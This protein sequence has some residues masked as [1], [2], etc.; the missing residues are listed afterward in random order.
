MSASSSGAAASSSSP[1][2]VKVIDSMD[3]RDS[4]ESSRQSEPISDERPS[5][6]VPTGNVS[7]GGRVSSS[8][9]SSARR[10]GELDTGSFRSKRRGGGGF[11][12]ADSFG[13]NR[14]ADLQ[15][16]GHRSPRDG[17]G[18]SKV[19]DEPLNVL[20]KRPANGR[21]GMNGSIRSSPLSKFT[22]AS[23]GDQDSRSSTEFDPAS[24]GPTNGENGTHQR[25]DTDENVPKPSGEAPLSQ[26]PGPAAGAIDPTQI[27][28]MALS[29]SESR[30]RNF[31]A[32]Q[33]PSQAISGRRVPSTG[34]TMTSPPLQGGYQNYGPGGSLRQYLNQQRRISRTISPG[35]T[36]RKTSGVRPASTSYFPSPPADPMGSPDPAVAPTYNWSTATLARVEKAKQYMELSSSHLGLLDFLPPLK[37]DSTAPGN[38]VYSASSV[39]GTA[40]FDLHRMQSK[41]NEKFPLGRQYNPLQLIRDR[42][43]RAR[44]RNCLNPDVDEFENVAQVREW[45]AAVEEGSSD[46]TYRGEDRAILPAYPLGSDPAAREA[47]DSSENGHRRNASIVSIRKRPRTDWLFS[48]AELLAEAYWLEQG[49]NKHLIENRHGNKIFPA[50]LKIEAHHPRASYEEKRSEYSMQISGGSLNGD[51]AD[52][53]S[54]RH[55]ERGRR[56]HLGHVDSGYK[57]RHVL[58]KARGRSP[59]P[60]S[61]LSTSDHEGR[62]SAKRPT[63]PLVT[64]FDDANVGPLERHME[65]ITGAEIQEPHHIGQTHISPG[66]PNKWGTDPRFNYLSQSP[67]GMA[68][69]DRIAHPETTA[70]DWEQRHSQSPERHLIH[71]RNIVDMDEPRSSMEE[72]SSTKPNSPIAEHFFPGLGSDLTPP[73]P[74]TSK[75]NRTHKS[76]K[77]IIPFIKSESSRDSRKLA[78]H[79]PFSDDSVFE[80]RPRKPSTEEAPP[81]S[82]FESMTGSEQGKKPFLHKT[83]ESI[84]SVG[85]RPSSRGKDAKD[86]KEP[87][88]AMR[89]FFKGGR[90]GE[91]VRTE[92]AKL[93]DAIRK[94]DSPQSLLEE[95]SDA[96]DVVAIESDSDEDL[97][98]VSAKPHE[99]VKRATT[100]S[101]SSQQLSP[102]RSDN[103]KP[104]FHIDNLPT[105]KSSTAK[106]SSE[107]SRPSTPT[108]DHISSQQRLL[109]QINR[110]PR[111]DRLAPP[112]LD[113]SRVTSR[114]ST[115]SPIT[116]TNQIYTTDSRDSRR[117][118]YGFPHLFHARSRSRLGKRLTA[119]LDVPGQVGRG[120]MPSTG[121]AKLKPERSASS[122]RRPQ[123]TMD[124]R[125]WSISDV[126]GAHPSV[127]AAHLPAAD[128]DATVSAADVTRVRA[129]LLCSGIKASELAWRAGH[130]RRAGP[131]P[132]LVRAAEASGRP[133]QEVVV[134]VREEF[135]MGGRLYSEVIE[136]DVD[137]LHASAQA[138]KD[139]KVSQL[140]HRIGD[141]RGVVESCS[142]RT[143]AMGDHAVGFGA[144][145]TGQRTIEVRMVMDSLDKLVRARR[146]RLRWL[147]RIG[148][149]LLEW[150][151][152]LFMWWV[153]FVVVVIKTGW[154][155]LRGL[156]FALRWILWLD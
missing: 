86:V 154:N 79:L 148:F 70:T 29:L 133:V 151:V 49:E 104:R 59:S 153:W 2:G 111:L 71:H 80:K 81:R 62:Q 113:I 58:N 115:T 56:R 95:D 112:S 55:V 48:P 32:G 47:P 146:R 130:P 139:G 74:Q 67:D 66:T 109:R 145:V 45:I 147:R 30:R 150:V 136:G 53:E 46:P 50:K 52:R 87:E 101:T 72:P 17:K 120:G 134:P 96:S 68:S 97:D 28:N 24:Y 35:N 69:R 90:I 1:R 20:K 11:L 6:E 124:K 117:S 88:S 116:N 26:A 43:L 76:R 152:L 85:A 123:L 98:S 99:V 78:G 5:L 131:N 23:S 149:G 77:G 127:V 57:L 51:D 34:P 63:L 8:G 9:P 12:L 83:N 65:K 7:T 155:V 135:A 108:Q 105:F 38:S 13:V 93:G 132:L 15:T 36:S 14:N 110:S 141:L 121:L 25:E 27:V 128:D 125:Q 18:K 103:Q 122:T 100:A 138:F 31:S 61:D 142:D 126:A 140:G 129:L 54:E 102:I 156:G 119:I 19:V 21:G 106:T 114:T 44:T 37:P 22:V 94:R 16:R 89:R 64:S 144:E 75:H 39:P 73:S 118:S 91:I 60:S 143:R 107:P 137:A 33:I 92:G 10:S 42:K 84:S 40:G 3:S 82:S 4:G 41:A